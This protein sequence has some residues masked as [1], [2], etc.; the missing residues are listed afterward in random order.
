MINEEDPYLTTTQS[1]RKTLQLK[2]REPKA[3]CMFYQLSIRQIT[4]PNDQLQE[5]L[6][7]KKAAQFLTN[8]RSNGKML[9][10]T[11]LS[12]RLVRSR[13]TCWR[14]QLDK[15]GNP[16]WRFP[17]I[18]SCS[19]FFKRKCEKGQWYIS[20]LTER[21][22]Q[23]KVSYDKQPRKGGDLIQFILGLRAAVSHWLFL[24]RMWNMN[25]LHNSL[26]SKINKWYNTIKKI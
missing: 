6:A 17:I 2:F 10:N 11:R 20:L 21:R 5:Q 1:N 7:W 13:L 16:K 26:S 19:F 4:S 22:L 9:E 14:N 25:A 24:P 23:Q 18:A 15:S 12:F 8:F 3:E